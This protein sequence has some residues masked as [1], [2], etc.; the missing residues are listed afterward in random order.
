[1][2]TKEPKKLVKMLINL[3]PMSQFDMCILGS[4]IC[5]QMGLPMPVDETREVYKLIVKSL[6][7]NKE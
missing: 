3:D 4:Y 6:K 5:G 2:K 7:S 1:M